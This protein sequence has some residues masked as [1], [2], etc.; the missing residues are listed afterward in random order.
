MSRT[1]TSAIKPRDLNSHRQITTLVA[2]AALALTAR[3]NGH[4]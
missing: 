4:L 3:L 2:N 1:S